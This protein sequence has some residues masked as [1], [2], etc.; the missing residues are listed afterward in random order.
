MD[1]Q[2]D[3][4]VKIEVVQG[5]L[6]RDTGDTSVRHLTHRPWDS[7]GP[8]IQAFI[9]RT[10]KSRNRH[11]PRTQGFWLLTPCLWDASEKTLAFSE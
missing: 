4:V 1:N 2:P 9:R 6:D 11:T 8:Q 7:T 5:G 10:G 3:N